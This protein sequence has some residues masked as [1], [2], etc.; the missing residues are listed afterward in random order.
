MPLFTRAPCWPQGTSGIQ[1]LV[2]SSLGTCAPVRRSG[3]PHAQMRSVDRGRRSQSPPRPGVSRNAGKSAASSAETGSGD[4]RWD[5]GLCSEPPLPGDTHRQA[6]GPLGSSTPCWPGP[7]PGIRPCGPPSLTQFPWK[8]CLQLPPPHLFSQPHL[9][10][11]VSSSSITRKAGQMPRGTFSWQSREKTG[12]W[13]RGKSCA[14]E[15]GSHP[16]SR[17]GSLGSIGAPP[18]AAPGPASVVLLRALTPCKTVH[19]GHPAPW[20]PTM[21][22]SHVWSAVG[23]QGH[24]PGH[25][26]QGHRGF[27]S[28]SLLGSC[29]RAPAPGP[30]LSH[31]IPESG[32]EVE[33][34]PAGGTSLF[35]PLLTVVGPQ[36]GAWRW[37]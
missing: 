18:W 16:L 30:G 35:H 3:N 21:S 4:S 17:G 36:G 25:S 10:G 14:R 22:L 7:A 20:R 29:S 32:K 26:H 19:D 2:T 37:G 5:R 6:G 28:P 1:E 24:S 12:I 13:A 27:V 15:A 33:V 9:L 23:M 8:G 11:G 31:I 34:R